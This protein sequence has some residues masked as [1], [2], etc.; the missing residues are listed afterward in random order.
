V[1]HDS[2]PPFEPGPPPIRAIPTAGTAPALPRPLTSFVGREQETVAVADLLARDDVRLLTLTGPGGVGKTRLSLRVSDQVGDRFDHTWFVALATVRNAGHVAPAILRALGIRQDSPRPLGA[3]V[4]HL[5]RGGSALLILDNVEQVLDAWPLVADL[6]ATCPRLTMLVTSRSP[7]RLAAEYVYQVPPMAL[8]ERG[9]GRDTLGSADALALF[10]ARAAAHDAGF[11]LT[12]GNIEAVAGICRALDGL[13]LAIELAAAR[14]SVFSPATIRDRLASNLALLAEGPRDQ[15]ERLR[16][17]RDSIAW[18]YELLDD[19]ERTLFRRLAVFAGPWTLDAAEAVAGVGDLPVLEGIASLV[20]SSLVRQVEGADGASRYAMLETIREF[21]AERLAES[22]EAATIRDRHAIWFVAL[23]ERTDWSWFKPRE[24]GEACLAELEAEQANLRAALGWLQRSGDADG[25]LRLAGRLGGF[26]VVN[27][28]LA[29]GEAW[30]VRA[31][32]GRG[33]ADRYRAQALGSL[34]WVLANM[35]RNDEAV[36]FGEECLTI[37]KDQEEGDDRT[38][39]TVYCLLTTA[40]AYRSMGNPDQCQARC[41]AVIAIADARDGPE[42]TRNW[43]VHAWIILSQNAIGRG[44]VDRAETCLR[45]VLDM[46]VARGHDPGTSHIYANQVV[47]GLGDVARARGDPV[48]AVRFFR[49]ALEL[50]RRSGDL[51]SQMFGLVAMSGALALAG[52]WRDAARLFGA[53][54]SL[55]ERYGYRFV[56]SMNVERALG[57]PEPWL[58][59]GESFGACQPL[60]DVLWGDRVVGLPPIPDPAAAAALWAAGRDL[61][62]ATA[63]AEA[64]KA[65]MGPPVEE[66]EERLPAGLSP[67]ELEVLRLLVEGGSDREIAD[68]LFISRRTAATHIRHIYDKLG[69]SSR[70]TAA[71]WAVRNGMA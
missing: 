6:L 29:E 65:G 50:G 7:L 42:W 66:G 56:D 41:E 8:P 23:A 40:A 69:V 10:V 27:G 18:S 4:A 54:E 26:W 39:G 57:L 61:D 3:E 5:T 68:A 36:V 63:V 21:A 9:A 51:R 62:I 59:A 31:L 37:R 34:T 17:M 33:G 45:R 16:S 11:A 1:S 38:F 55:H 46:Q 60:R 19:A 58:R 43:A 47:K 2:V 70:A 53:S 52:N 30:L 22:G 14:V 15:P 24:V 71:A 35:H 25:L 44:D 32:A 48:D 67:R 12:A 28:H 13:P 49:R 20:S 64:L